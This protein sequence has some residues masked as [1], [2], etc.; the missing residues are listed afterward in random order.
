MIFF[1]KGFHTLY[2]GYYHDG[3]RSGWGME[4]PLRN[5]KYRL[6]YVGQ[7]EKDMRL[8]A[9]EED[10]IE[11]HKQMQNFLNLELASII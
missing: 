7:F 5:R 4:I 9:K 10:K 2:V 8:F 11:R 1:N 6:P 3:M